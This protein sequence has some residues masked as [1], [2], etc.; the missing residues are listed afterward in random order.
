MPTWLLPDHIS[1]V[2][3]SEALRVERLRRRLLDCYAAR[4]Y[5]FFIPPLLEHV[6]SLRVQGADDLERRSFKFTDPGSGRLLSL[7]PDITPQAVRVDAHLMDGPPLLRGLSRSRSA[8]GGCLE[9]RAF[10]GGLRAL[11]GRGPRGRPRDP[12]SRPGVVEPGRAR[13]RASEPLRP[14]R[15]RGTSGAGARAGRRRGRGD[16]GPRSQRSRSPC[17]GHQGSRPRDAAWASV[18]AQSLW[19]ARWPG[20]CPGARS[21]AASVWGLLAGEP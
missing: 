5:Q 9:P 13:A 10:P 15:P 3:P 18:S 4:G 21:A 7:R 19:A 6:E 1:D 2:L 14:L 11:W 16:P 8:L 12:I 20:R 17:A